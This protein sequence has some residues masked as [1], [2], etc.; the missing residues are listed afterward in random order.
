MK[1]FLSGSKTV[2]HLPKELTDLLDFWCM[3]GAEFLI[4]DCFGADRLMLEYLL[5][6]GCSRVTVCVS[7]PKSRVPESLCPVLHIPVSDDLSGFAF[8][9]KK[10]VYM[11]SECDR[12]IML[13]DG[14]TR[15][16]RC[17]IEDI[18][19]FRKPYTVICAD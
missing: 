8:Y 4:G 19:R 1:I 9:R 16:T 10:D 18:R 14:K 11:L 6:K 2:T 15:G 12:A 7:G 13:W 5:Q 3:Q 17:N